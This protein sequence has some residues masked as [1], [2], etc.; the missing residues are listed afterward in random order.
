VV[1]SAASSVSA[2]TAD[3]PAAPKRRGRPAKAK[4]ETASLAPA[5]KPTVET[6]AKP[7]GRPARV[8]TAESSDT[9]DTSPEPVIRKQRGRAPRISKTE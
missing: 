9:A 3:T 4:P 2:D 7:R 8:K 1:E 6:S 5:E